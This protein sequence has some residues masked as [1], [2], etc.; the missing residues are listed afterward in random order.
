[1]G[2]KKATTKN[3]TPIVAHEIKPT[4]IIASAARRSERDIGPQPLRPIDARYWPAAVAPIGAPISTTVNVWINVSGRTN[5]LNKT[6][7]ILCEPL[8]HMHVYDIQESICVSIVNAW[9]T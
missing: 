1:M 7:I 2:E 9:L 6:Y 4:Y 5:L 8:Q 3:N